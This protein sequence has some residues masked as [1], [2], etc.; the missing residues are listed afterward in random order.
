MHVP[1]LLGRSAA[2]IVYGTTLRL[3][4]EFSHKYIVDAHTDLDNYS[5]KLRV[6]MSCLRL[7]PPRDSPQNNIFQYKKID[8]CSHVFLRRIAI[9]PPMTAPYNG[10]YKVIVRSGRVIKIL[11]KGKVEKVSLDRVKPA[12]LDSEPDTGTEKQRKT[13][14]NTKNSK[15]TATVQRALALKFR[16]EESWTESKNTDTVCGDSK[17]Y[18]FGHYFTA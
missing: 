7:C 4:R 6:A 5:E 8:T 3:P 9:A 12:H 17:W 1:P 15:N 13:Q 14:N 16:K 11:I 2:E 18:E 10:P